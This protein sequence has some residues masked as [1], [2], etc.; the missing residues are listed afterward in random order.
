MNWM[1]S[2]RAINVYALIADN[3]SD[4]KLTSAKKLMAF[5]FLL[6]SF[7]LEARTV[8][9]GLDIGDDDRILFRATSGGDGSPR[10]SAIFAADIVSGVVA[11]LTAFPEKT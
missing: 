2:L 4:M 8:F 5:A 11:Q 6:A 3:G 1:S 9:D 10:Q 7:S